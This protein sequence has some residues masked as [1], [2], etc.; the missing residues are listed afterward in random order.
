VPSGPLATHCIAVLQVEHRHKTGTISVVSWVWA[1]A[2]LIPVRGSSPGGRFAPSVGAHTMRRV[3]VRRK[4]RPDFRCMCGYQLTRRKTRMSD[5]SLLWTLVTIV[6]SV[7]ASV[8]GA[9]W[10]LKGQLTSAELAGLREQNAALTAWRG[11]AEAQREQLAEELAEA[12][13]T[14]ATLQ[15]Q[16]AE[17]ANKEVLADSAAS[18]S[19]AIVA[20][21]GTLARGL[22]MG[23]PLHVFGEFRKQRP[24][25]ER[26]RDGMIGK[27]HPRADRVT[28]HQL[29][30]RA[31][32]GPPVRIVREIWARLPRARKTQ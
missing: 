25:I 5:L 22:G 9:A 26:L 4:R 10:W 13:A 29:P 24:A 17:G 28:L 27:G 7:F 15:Q 31:T 16:I 32:G 3:G 11:F 20:A 14:N 30:R 1:H 21:E 6:G 2:P 8:A 23:I 18:S 12:K 19:R